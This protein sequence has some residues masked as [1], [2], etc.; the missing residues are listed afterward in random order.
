MIRISK[1]KALTA[2]LL[3][4]GGATW[5]APASAQATRTWVSGV[6]DDVNP[7][8]RTAPCKTF[9][10][11]I[12]KTAAG[13]EINCL[14]PGAYGALTITKSI[15]I[16]CQYTEAG[17]L[18]TLGSTGITVNAAATDTIFLS[19]LDI[20]G[21][22]GANPGAN[23]V[24]IL[25]AGNVHIENSTIRNFTSANGLGV[26]ITPSTN[27]QVTITNT[28]I[29]TNGSGVTGGGIL[30]TPGAGGSARV[31]LENVRVQYNANNQ[32]RI[33]T[34]GSTGGVTLNVE[35]S[36]FLG[37]GAG[38]SVNVPAGTGSVAGMINEATISL[39]G[40]GIAANGSNARLRVGN[41][42]ITATTTGV[43]ATGSAIINTYGNNRLD[44]NGSNGAFT[45]PEIPDQ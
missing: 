22:G 32:L 10:G 20:N 31:T 8:S 23:G 38:I 16:I 43:S 45:L 19:G 33:D 44:G 11:A 27:S 28:T 1:R 13:G 40:T 9:A 39:T 25:A 26:R 12:S 5:A 4:A 35:D 3:A 37:G 36:Q 6:G 17:V 29:T 21:G 2:M 18:A 34:T 41:S 14:D 42:T 30:I 24:R 15:S 7:C